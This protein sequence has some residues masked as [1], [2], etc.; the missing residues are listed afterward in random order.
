MKPLKGIIQRRNFLT[1]D[2]E[3]IPGYNTKR[4][5][6]EGFEPN[7][8]RLIGV[9]DGKSY[10]YYTKIKDFLNGEMTSANRGRWFFAHAGGLADVRYVLEYLLDNRPRGVRVNAAFSGSS[11]IIVKISRGKNHW[12]LLDSYWLIRQP[13]RKIGSWVG[14]EKG[15]SEDSIDMFYAPIDVLV[16]YNKRDCRILWQAIRILEDTLIKHGGRLE[17]TIA[18]CALGLFRRAFLKRE[19]TPMP[20]NNLAGRDAYKASRVEVFEKVCEEGDYFDVNSSF[21][22]SMTF[23][24]P[25]NYQT[26]SKHLIDNRLALAHCKVTIDDCYLPPIPYRNP[27]DKRVYFPVGTWE[28]WF[29]NIDLELIQESKTGIIESIKEVRYFEPFDDLAAY[30]QTI[31]ELRRTCESEAEKVVL[32]FLLNSLYGKFGEG[33]IK[34]RIMIN[35]SESFFDID[36]FDSENLEYPCRSYIMPGVYELIEKKDIPHA[37]VPIANHI[38]A[39]SRKL[40]YDF[41]VKAS[42]VYYCDTDGFACPE[43]DTFETS[44]RLGGLKKEKHIHKGHFAAPKLYAYQTDSDAP[45]VIKAK[46]FSRVRGGPNEEGIWIV[47]DD[48]PSRKISYEDFCRLLEHKDLYVEQASRIRSSL[49]K[50]EYS[51]HDYVHS[52]RWVDKVRPK[53]YFYADGTSRAWDVKELVK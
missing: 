18:S 45:W 15:G 44:D 25:G 14:E 5:K 42:K 10:R 20:D 43:T 11:A 21:P 50:G 6:S 46:G 24:A 49:K 38:T 35:P 30:A 3:W 13:L 32:K 19:I 17:K 26:T 4:A 1:Y 37:H 36:E 27:E 48:D 9:Y 12:Y 28:G 7:Q 16:D 51:P 41:M 2:L 33:E 52:K 31:Y 39:L 22:Y 8:L 40:L 47:K 34:S 23:S 29:S 53:R